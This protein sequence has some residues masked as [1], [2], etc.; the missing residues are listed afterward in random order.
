MFHSPFTALNNSLKPNWPEINTGTYI[1]RI[2]ANLNDG[3]HAWKDIWH[4][5]W[6]TPT[7]LFESPRMQ[8]KCLGFCLFFASEFSR[9]PYY[10]II[11][12]F[13]LS[14]A[15]Q[16]PHNPANEQ[17]SAQT[18]KLNCP[19]YQY[20]NLKCL[21]KGQKIKPRNHSAFSTALTLWS[22][23]TRWCVLGTC[24]V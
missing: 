11:I 2:R 8:S 16:N 19:M 13:F 1:S 3:N 9:Y 7:T 5:P 4:V 17:L 20:W 12:V 24:T 18:N 21:N 14:I 15:L 23:W 6:P 22:Q 10:F